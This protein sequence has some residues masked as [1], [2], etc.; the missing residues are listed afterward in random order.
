M[1]GVTSTT[2][3]FEVKIRQAKLGDAVSHWNNRGYRV[4]KGRNINDDQMIIT[5]WKNQYARL[6]E[7]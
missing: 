6:G 2:P 3:I 1:L 4:C 5:V 7:I